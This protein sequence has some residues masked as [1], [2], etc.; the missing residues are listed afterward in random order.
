MAMLQ[1]CDQTKICSV[2]YRMLQRNV[3]TGPTGICVSDSEI[4]WTKFSIWTLENF[5]L[6]CAKFQVVIRA[7]RKILN[8]AN[9]LF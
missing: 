6:G 2:Q 7:S 4:D 5:D 8:E 1:H 3:S 9:Y